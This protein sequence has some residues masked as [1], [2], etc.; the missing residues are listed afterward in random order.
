MTDVKKYEMAKQDQ[1][2]LAALPAFINK[3]LLRPETMNPAY[4][5]MGM[6]VSSPSESLTSEDVKNEAQAAEANAQL[7]FMQDMWARRKKMEDEGYVADEEYTKFNPKG[8][9]LFLKR[10]EAPPD[11]RNFFEKLTGATQAAN[12]V[13]TNPVQAGNNV[14]TVNIPT[15]VMAHYKWAK[16]NPNDP[17]AKEILRRL[18]VKY[19]NLEE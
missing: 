12:R 10:P 5:G 8:G 14:A 4:N 1:L 17:D 3:G 16:A 18:K 15:N 9:E 2:N 6:R 11:E 13:V 7:A 19:P